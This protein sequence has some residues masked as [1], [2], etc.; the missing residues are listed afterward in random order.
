PWQN[1]PLAAANRYAQAQ[2]FADQYVQ[3]NYPL[4]ANNPA[5][6]PGEGQTAIDAPGTPTGAANP[7]GPPGQNTARGNP[8]DSPVGFDSTL[9]QNQNQIGA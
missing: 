5:A 1:G 9:T 8:I 4:P 6:A 7:I 2:G 3:E